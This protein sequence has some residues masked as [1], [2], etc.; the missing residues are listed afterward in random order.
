MLSKAFRFAPFTVGRAAAQWPKYD[1]GKNPSYDFTRWDQ[2]TPPAE[3]SGFQKIGHAYDFASDQY[4]YEDHSMHMVHQR[5]L[6]P[7]WTW[8]Y[9]WIVALMAPAYYLTLEMPFPGVILG[10]YLMDIE[11][12]ATKEAFKEE[13]YTDYEAETAKYKEWVR[14]QEEEEDEDDE[15]E[16]EEEEEEEEEA[17]EEE[18]EDDE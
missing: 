8:I 7:N 14:K 6:N 11:D 17:A 2:D 4:D 16:E 5:H 3:L 15:D 10:H 9:W 12:N 18:E 1:V 13:F